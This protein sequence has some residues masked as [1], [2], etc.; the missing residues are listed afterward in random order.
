MTAHTTITHD[1]RAAGNRLYEILGA[2][3][4]Y[5]LVAALFGLGCLI[6]GEFLTV[7]NLRNTLQAVTL[8]GIVAVGVAFITYS[9]H[10]V[11]LSIPGIMALSGMGAASRRDWRSASSTAA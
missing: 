6:S 8:L 5:V 2:L 10:Y 1:R 9:Q 7:Q 3:G 11:D 4:A